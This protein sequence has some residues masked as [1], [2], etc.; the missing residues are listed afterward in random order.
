[1]KILKT[2]ALA[3][4]LLAAYPAFAQTPSPAMQAA[5]SRLQIPL[6]QLDAMGD[7]DAEQK[8]K[9]HRQN[10]INHKLQQK[11]A[12]DEEYQ[13]LLKGLEDKARTAKG[14]DMQKVKQETDALKQKKGDLD[15][16]LK[17]DELA[18]A[19]DFETIESYLKD[20]KDKKKGKGSEADIPRLQAEIKEMTLALEQKKKELAALEKQSGKGTAKSR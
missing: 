16:K 18:T 13:R 8:V 5:T 4:A 20:K 1:M 3:A 10:L 9:A 14:G 19:K 6:Q 7:D 11:K 2:A 15:K 17:D 12:Q